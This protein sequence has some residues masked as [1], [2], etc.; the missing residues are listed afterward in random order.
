M[1]S[2]EWVDQQTLLSDILVMTGD[3]DLRNGLSRGFY[4][5]RIQQAIEKLAIS[6][7]YDVITG[8]FPLPKQLISELP[9]NCFNIRE[10]YLWNG[11][12]CQPEGSVIVH[13]KRLFNNKPGNGDGNNFTALRMNN[14]IHNDPF[15]GNW[16]YEW[17]FGDGEGG[18][19][20]LYYANIQNGK[21]MFSSNAQ[22]YSNYRIVY[23]GFG[24]EIGNP[25]LVPRLLREVTQ[26]MVICSIFQAKMAREPRT[27][28]A[29][30][31]EYN[32]KLYN[33]K[34]GTFFEAKN[35]ISAMNSWARKDYEEYQGHGD[36]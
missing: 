35:R 21:I 20:R 32:D 17:G 11:S 25:P 31:R 4:I 10:I 16:D 7:F 27:Y 34:S 5:S 18:C 2:G 12:C 19:G 15:Y 9:I 24:G 29:L 1:D 22:G 26:D 33:Y 3:V 8:D 28:M 23:N 6:T 30:Y 14:Q 13:F 36:W